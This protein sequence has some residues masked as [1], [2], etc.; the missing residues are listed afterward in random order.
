MKTGVRGDLL[1]DTANSMFS[2]K[3]V[4]YD[5]YHRSL[6]YTQLTQTPHAPAFRLN[7]FYYDVHQK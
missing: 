5:M 3:S 6:E 2:K 4:E 7:I 1:A